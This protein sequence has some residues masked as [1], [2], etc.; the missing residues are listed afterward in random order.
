MLDENIKIILGTLKTS[1]L[2]KFDR[3]SG[4]PLSTTSTTE[5]FAFSPLSSAPIHD[6][7]MRR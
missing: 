4:I 2:S 5:C 3:V 6:L 1:T 7:I